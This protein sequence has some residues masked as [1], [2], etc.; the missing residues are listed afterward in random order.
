MAIGIFFIYLFLLNEANFACIYWID[1]GPSWPA[2]GD[3]YLKSG[4]GILNITFKCKAN[5]T[6]V[7]LDQNLYVEPKPILGQ[8]REKRLRSK[9]ISEKVHYLEHK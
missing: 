6:I 2:L 9:C 1:Y 3:S 4:A 8:R 5:T 7:E